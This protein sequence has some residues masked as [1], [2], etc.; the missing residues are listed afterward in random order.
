MNF[1]HPDLVV[2][3]AFLLA[4]L[5]LPQ[6]AA[7]AEDPPANLVLVT[8]D[9]VRWQEVF[10][11]IDLDLIEDERYTNSPELLKVHLNMRL[12]RQRLPPCLR[13]CFLSVQ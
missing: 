10:G 13:Q 4:L 12:W 8:L 2:A 3:T 5:F 1:R 9:G 6:H 7:R 11:G